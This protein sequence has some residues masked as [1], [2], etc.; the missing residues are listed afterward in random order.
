MSRASDT[1]SRSILDTENL[2]EHLNTLNSKP[3]PPEI[4]ALKRAVLV[5]AMPYPS[6]LRNESELHFASFAKKAMAFARN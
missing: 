3:P 5:M 1:F 4:E 6:V 2:L